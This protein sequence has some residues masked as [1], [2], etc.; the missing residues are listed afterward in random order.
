MPANPREAAIRPP[1][2]IRKSASID[3]RKSHSDERKSRISI[4]RSD[5]SRWIC[6]AVASS[7]AT[8]VSIRRLSRG[9]VPPPM[10]CPF[11]V[12]KFTMRFISSRLASFI[13]NIARPLQN[14]TLRAYC[15]T[16]SNRAVQHFFGPNPTRRRVRGVATFR[17]I[18]RETT[19]ASGVTAYAGATPLR[20]PYFFSGSEPVLGLLNG[21]V[22]NIDLAWFCICSCI[23]TN[24]F[25]DCSM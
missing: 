20:A 18:R 9:S 19:R 21:N 11:R 7:L 5:T 23:C 13:S 2:V 12:G 10:P 14:P 1:H 25:F 3:E 8:R 17:P 6:S 15:T 4:L 24:M 16:N 22:L